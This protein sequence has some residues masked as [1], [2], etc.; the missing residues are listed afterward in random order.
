M[1]S[2]LMLTLKFT[3]A[4]SGASR[5]S[6]HGHGP[7]GAGG[8]SGLGDFLFFLCLESW[9]GVHRLSGGE[10]RA[11]RLWFDS[12]IFVHGTIVRSCPETSL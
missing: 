7:G 1:I 6:A 4:G 3:L 10:G 12:V 2:K 5:L 9:E 11:G 8:L